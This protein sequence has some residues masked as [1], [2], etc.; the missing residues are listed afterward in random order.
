MQKIQ[1]K[2][3]HAFGCG[4]TGWDESSTEQSAGQRKVPL[5]N[6]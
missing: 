1:Q 2:G 3:M 5:E 6:V 4:F